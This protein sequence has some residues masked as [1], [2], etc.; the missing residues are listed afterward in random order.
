MM[1]AAA[2]KG[3]S[4]TNH[5]WWAI[6]RTHVN[7]RRIDDGRSRRVDDRSSL[8]D[9]RRLL[10]NDRLRLNHRCR[11]RYNLLHWLLDHDL[12]DRRLLDH[13]SGRLLDVNR[14]RRHI[15]GRRFE[16]FCDEQACPHACQDFTRCRPAMVM[17]PRRR[18]AGPQDRQ[19]CR[20]YQG[21][22]HILFC[23]FRRA[24]CYFIQQR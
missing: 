20:C 3:K 10:H 14:S 6:I 16:C 19:G 22:F 12:L 13:H 2:T 5:G 23:W 17:G 18:D 7:G 9:N 8:I 24:R 11:L 15:H 21:F 4:E 1:I